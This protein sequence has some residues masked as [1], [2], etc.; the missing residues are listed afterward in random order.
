MNISIKDY[1]QEIINK[2]LQLTV[3][4]LLLLKFDRFNMHKEGH[5]SMMS[6]WPLRLFLLWHFCKVHHS[7]YEL[8]GPNHWVL[9]NDYYATGRPTS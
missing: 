8:L 3:L 4:L 2:C 1:H 7:G 6:V 5:R 9:A